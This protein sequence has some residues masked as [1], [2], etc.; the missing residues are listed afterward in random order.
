MVYNSQW[1]IWI[2]GRRE[3]DAAR[4]PIVFVGKRVLLACARPYASGG[5]EWPPVISGV[6]HC[7]PLQVGRCFLWNKMDDTFDWA[8]VPIYY[9]FVGDSVQLSRGESSTLHYTNVRSFLDV[10]DFGLMTNEFLCW[11]IGFH[12]CLNR[13]YLYFMYIRACVFRCSTLPAI[14]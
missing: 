12:A 6:E 10:F 4:A 3:H 9:I 8:R 2:D 11:S 13:K 7:W 14:V 5:V 1:S